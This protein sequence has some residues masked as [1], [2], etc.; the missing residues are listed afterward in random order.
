MKRT[1]LSFIALLPLWALALP[2]D[3]P[4]WENPAVFSINKEAPR[5]TAL[6]Y[7][8]EEQAIKDNYIASPYYLSLNGLWKF[9]WA[10]SPELRPA[11]FYKEDYDTSNWDEIEVPSNWELK[12]YGTPIYTNIN[13]PY[14]KNPPY[15]PHYDNPTGSYKRTFDLPQAWKDRRVY[16]HFEAGTSAM[17]VWVNGKKVGYS[18]VTKSP[19]EFDITPYVRSG[20]NSLAVEVYRW[21]DGSYLEDQDFW[22][23]SGIDRNVYLYSTEQVRIADFEVCPDLDVAYKNGKLNVSVILRNYAFAPTEKITLSYSLINAKGKQIFKSDRNV[24]LKGNDADTLRITHAVNRPALW[25]NETPTL[26]TVLLTLKAADGRII[27]STS[28]R[29]GFRKVEIKDGILL[30]NGKPLLIRG[31]NLHEHHP[32]TGHVVDTATMLSDIRSMK[33]YNINAVRTSHYPQSPLW[34]K[35]CDQYGLLVCDEANIESHGMGSEPGVTGRPE[36]ESRHAAFLPEWK[37][38]HHDRVK[39]LVERDK[40]HPCVIIWSMGNECG[41]GEVFYEIYRWLKQR[42]PSRPVQFEQAGENSNTDIV[43]PM[44]PAIGYMKEYASR[45]EAQ[46]PFIMCEYAHAMG[47]SSGNFQEYFD[48]MATSPHM[49]GGFIWD[50][51]DQGLSATDDNGRAY[52]GYGGDFGAEN[53]THDENFCCNGLVSP[54]RQPHPGLYEVKKV[55]QD[56]LFMPHDIANGI[57]TIKNR[58]LYTNVSS[59]DL[60]W[61]LS[62]NG[63]IIAEGSLS[64]DITA[65][66]ARNIKLNLP[67]LKQEPGKEYFV[68]LYAYTR[69]A[70]ELLPAGHEIAREQIAL[71]FNDYFTDS[72]NNCGT[73]KIEKDGFAVRIECGETVAIF[74]TQDGTLL[75][76]SYRGKELL[77]GSPEPCFWRAPTDNDYG[78]NMPRKCNVWRHAGENRTVKEV[79]TTE[80]DNRFS[81]KTVYRLT[82]IDSYYEMV[83]TVL[84]DGKLQLTGNWKSQRADLPPMP[85]FGMLWTISHAYENLT[86]YGRGHW[87]NYS[88]RKTAANI[89]LYR[90]TVTEQYHPYVR[91]Q[92]N[93]YKT[94]VRYLTLTDNDGSGIRID[95]IQPICFSALH[96][97]TEDFDSGATK[98]QRHINDV[99][100]RKDIALH[101]DLAQQGVGGDN[102]WGAMPH[103]PYLLQ[104]DSYSYSYT[105]SPV[106]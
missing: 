85:R 82:D 44:Y 42:D 1:A 26:Y 100:P 59:Y 15:I 64:P 2:V 16:L 70:T 17:Y 11:D 71:P 93:G 25:S 39:R 102:S 36:I 73:M 106:R 31:V 101:I 86:W 21:S 47:N 14:P 28:C 38:A 46:R 94:D 23:L 81:M 65:G 30:L 87:E 95:G 32:A 43:C 56:I 22:R 66:A 67:A 76:Y 24:M 97:A 78:W 29:T 74:N 90:S 18:Q 45:K 104:D 33:L 9:S 40:N 51:V 75:S 69:N 37:A 48:I 58:F 99:H 52:W 68:N 35:L 20:S 55:Y 19:A 7:A 4:D 6:P 62:E 96:Y 27:E 50:W 12:G 77:Q 60:R 91:P 105:I 5:A 49:Q 89:G 84:P 53:Y 80:S 79:K 98:K 63:I 54:D 103:S 61:Q 83:Y 57:I 41:N 3:T 92:E 34:Y 10:Q 13:Y 88:D 72:D 8:T